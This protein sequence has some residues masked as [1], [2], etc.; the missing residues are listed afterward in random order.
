MVIDLPIC[1]V[2][3]R[4]LIKQNMQLHFRGEKIAEIKTSAAARL[5]NRD[6]ELIS[7]RGLLFLRLTRRSQASPV[8]ANFE[9]AL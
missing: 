3:I 9:F 1:K 8:Q 4:A 6:V 7:R 5:L 2:F